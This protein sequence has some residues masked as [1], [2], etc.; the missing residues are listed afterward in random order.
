MIESLPSD[1]AAVAV[2]EV[3]DESDL[4]YLPR[5][6]AMEILSSVSS[7]NG[8]KHTHNQQLQCHSLAGLGDHSS[9]GGCSLSGHLRHSRW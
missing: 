3:V 4:D 8:A 1:P 2:D 5:R 6:P 9:A 7:G